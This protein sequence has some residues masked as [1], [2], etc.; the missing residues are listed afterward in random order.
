MRFVRWERLMRLVRSDR[1][2]SSDDD[3]DDDDDE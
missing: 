3:D 2:I 1:L